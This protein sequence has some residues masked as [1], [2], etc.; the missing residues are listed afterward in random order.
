MTI[1]Q[2]LKAA[3]EL[4]AK[5]WTQGDFARN[6]EGLRVDT[7]SKDA[8][9]WCVMGAIHKSAETFTESMEAI[10]FLQEKVTGNVMRFN[11][12]HTHVEVLAALDKAIGLAESGGR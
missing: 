6:A 8:T 10:S 12:S 11:D 4:I 9:S 5:Y 1:G 2:V 3:R 7:R